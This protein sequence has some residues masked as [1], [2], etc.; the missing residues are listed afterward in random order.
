MI[1]SKIQDED[2]VK[3]CETITHIEP[4][5][6][7]KK[8]KKNELIY[9]KN[10]TSSMMFKCG[11]D[12][13]IPHNFVNISS[14][15]SK[16][17]SFKETFLGGNYFKPSG[18][19]VEETNDILKKLHKEKTSEKQTNNVLLTN[20]LATLPNKR[21]KAENN[22]VIINQSAS[23]D[24]RHINDISSH[25]DITAKKTKECN[26]TSQNKYVTANL[27]SKIE[28][29]INTN[30]KLS[31]KIAFKLLSS[32]VLTGC[33]D[34]SIRILYGLCLELAI[35]TF[36][37]K[38]KSIVVYKELIK[39]WV[40]SSE[41]YF[42]TKFSMSLKTHFSRGLNIHPYTNLSRTTLSQ[43][44]PFS[45]IPVE[46]IRTK[47][48]IGQIYDKPRNIKQPKTIRCKTKKTYVKKHI[49]NT[50]LIAVSIAL[51]RMIILR[52]TISPDLR[53]NKP[54]ADLYLRY[55]HRLGPLLG[56]RYTPK[57]H[58]ESVFSVK[59]NTTNT[60]DKYL[61]PAYCRTSRHTSKYELNIQDSIH[62]VCP[63]AYLKQLSINNTKIQ[64]TL[65]MIHL[66]GIGTKKCFKTSFKYF[67]LCSQSLYPPAFLGMAYCIYQQYVMYDKT[68]A[69]DLF[70]LAAFL[71]ND[72][73]LYYLGHV[74][75]SYSYLN[76]RQCLNKSSIAY[77]L[78]IL[79]AK[80]NNP[81]AITQLAQ[82]K[83]KRK[84]H[85]VAFVFYKK[86]A[87]RGYPP[88]QYL[89][90]NYY[91]TKYKNNLLYFYWL[92]TAA[93]QGLA[94]ALH[95]LAFMCFKGELQQCVFLKK[96]NL[97]FT[98]TNIITK[99]NKSYTN[100]I[101]LRL[102]FK[103]AL[104]LN[105]KALFIL[106][107]I[108]ITKKYKHIALNID[109]KNSFEISLLLY[110]IGA[111]QNHSESLIALSFIYKTGL[112]KK[113]NPLK[114]FN[115]MFTAAKLHDKTAQ[116]SIGRFFNEGFG[117][118]K[119]L[120]KA[121]FWYAKSASQAFP[122][123]QCALAYLIFKSDSFKNLRKQAVKYLELSANQGYIK[124]F[125]NLGY[126]YENGMVYKKNYKKAFKYYNVA[127]M[128][129]IPYSHFNTGR[130]YQDG[131]GIKFDFTK[132]LVCYYK[133]ALAGDDRCLK[134]IKAVLAKHINVKYVNLCRCA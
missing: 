25:Q 68:C 86:A 84:E 72:S 124:A 13:I 40:G 115:L 18:Q 19:D 79:S 110:E 56:S 71:G 32:L 92:R 47:P 108:L 94:C 73:S 128:G 44:K 5:E 54:E 59:N 121:I 39:D 130:C 21:P 119:N 26:I 126:C 102:L 82:T 41:C 1:D 4:L 33:T 50:P 53:I 3:E 46:T 81:M 38:H 49:Y 24:P 122:E 30:E 112:Y 14:F 125:D 7:T 89:L 111:I 83:E 6:T 55:L 120:K 131:L 87:K 127:A 117:T 113:K 109:I 100:T 28:G 123:A 61:Y 93:N 36:N 107:T 2:F 101:G 70:F 35:G 76:H 134:R 48:C 42:T 105:P 77:S 75:Y 91:K 85:N 27:L 74:F 37:N 66:N 58:R 45:K 57:S 62:C 63:I 29:L 52:T 80:K 22:T 114:S 8:L 12:D 67:Y 20:K 98:N 97:C 23:N 95:E 132:A 69:V 31:Q 64:Y 116:L 99:E 65:A 9:E 60:L 11:V 104:S 51:I 129:D 16:K 88:A 17:G 96:Y 15:L 10:K 34:P 103:S 118:R 133:G 106:A 78:Y 90:S 43:T